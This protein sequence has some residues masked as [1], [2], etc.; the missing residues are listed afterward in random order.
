MTM[1]ERIHEWLT[2]RGLS[3][4][5]IERYGLS[6]TGTHIAIP[7]RKEDGTTFNK[8]RRDP[9]T[10]EGDKFYTDTGGS[11]TLVFWNEVKDDEAIL[12]VEGELDAIRVWNDGGKAITCST[13]ARSWDDEW[14]RRFKDKEVFLWYDEDA[15]GIGGAMFAGSSIARYARC[16]WAV[17]HGKENGKDLT[18]FLTVIGMPYSE[19]LL[20]K[21]KKEPINKV[22]L[23]APERNVSTEE[24][25]NIGEVMAHYGIKLS[26]KPQ[27]NI[28]CPFHDEKNPSLSVSLERGLWNCHA[29]CGGGDAYTFVELK[30]G[31]DFRTAKE[32]ISKL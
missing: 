30:E 6:W 13:G 26:G 23:R 16:V 17:R 19:K 14:S 11:K 24:R 31:C 4:E 18:E 2:K 20:R 10:S 32:F 5:T 8:Y 28:L 29:G 1:P 15:T 3:S 9:D 22:G 7:I 27:E 12:I 21:M 25:P